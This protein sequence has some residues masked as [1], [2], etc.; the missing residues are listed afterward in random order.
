M[1]SK[2]KKANNFYLKIYLRGVIY[3]YKKKNQKV[4]S[5]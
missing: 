2:K 3:Y 5:N 4:V 1:N